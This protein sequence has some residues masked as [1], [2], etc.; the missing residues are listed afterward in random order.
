M[1]AELSTRMGRAQLL[2]LDE[3]VD[4]EGLLDQGTTMVMVLEEGAPL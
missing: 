4:G 3:A 1:R 2:L